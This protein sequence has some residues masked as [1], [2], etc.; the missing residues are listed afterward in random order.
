M[1]LIPAIDLLQ[2]KAVRLLRGSFDAVTVYH[3]DPVELAREWSQEVRRLHVVDLQG[4]KAGA[5]AELSLIARLVKA[6]GPGVQVGGGVRSLETLRSYFALGVERVVLGTAALT[7]PELVDAACREFP[8]RVILAV[9]AR[10]GLVAT[11]GWLSQSEVRAVDVVRRHAGT[12]LAAVLYTDIERDGTEIGPNIAET[13][14]LAR[15]GGVPVLVSGGVGTLRHLQSLV[16][17]GVEFSGVIVGRAL[18][19][20]RFTLAQA[21]AALGDPA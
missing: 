2:G 10:N 7:Q 6:F 5:P 9:D 11:Q 19:E 18:H 4:S 17:S 15:D 13:A 3:E 8:G 16:E 21:L 1:D 20:H 14:T 12:R